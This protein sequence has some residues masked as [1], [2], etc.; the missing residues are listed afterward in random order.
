[1][2]FERENK[3][4]YS[5]RLY[6]SPV[7]SFVY[8]VDIS[9]CNFFIYVIIIYIILELM[10]HYLNFSVINNVLSLSICVSLKEISFVYI[11]VVLAFLRQ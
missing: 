3:K 7:S 1:M 5:L 11:Q 10:V 4:C 2:V 6:I 9:D 8:I